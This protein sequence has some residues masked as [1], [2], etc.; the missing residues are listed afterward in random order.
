M[1]V[2]RPSAVTGR[3]RRSSASSWRACEQV[4]AAPA[5]DRRAP[6][7]RST[8]RS[9]GWRP[10]AGPPG[11][12]PRRRPRRPGGENRTRTSGRPGAGTGR[13]STSAP[14]N[15]TSTRRGRAG[16]QRRAGATSGGAARP[17]PAR[18]S[19]S[20][21]RCS[22]RPP[23]RRPGC[24][25]GARRRRP[26]RR[27]PR[28]GRPERANAGRRAGHRRGG[29]ATDGGGLAGVAAPAARLVGSPASRRAGQRPGQRPPAPSARPPPR[30]TPSCDLPAMADRPDRRRAGDGPGVAACRRQRRRR[31]VLAPRRGGGGRRRRLRPGPPRAPVRGRL[32]AS[33]S[34]DAGRDLAAPPPPPPARGLGPRAFSSVARLTNRASA[35]LRFRTPPRPRPSSPARRSPARRGGLPARAR[36]ARSPELAPQPSISA[37]GPRLT[38]S[39]R[40]CRRLGGGQPPG[41]RAL[42]SPRRV[43]ARP[44]RGLDRGEFVGP[45]LGA[46][47]PQPAAPTDAVLVDGLRHPGAELVVPIHDPGD[48][49]ERRGDSLAKPEVRPQG[50]GGSTTGSAVRPDRAASRAAST[51]GRIPRRVGQLSPAASGERRPPRTRAPS[52]RSTAAPVPH[53]RQ[54]RRRPTRGARPRPRPAAHRRR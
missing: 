8:P 14:S 27:A 49:R 51:A 24:A 31:S 42:A 1:T 17:R 33:G 32:R 36:A 52:I 39:A 50:G 13:G 38:V 22:R 30:P 41:R 2:R 19:R 23:G 20:S 28:R 15:T 10:G 12:A 18:A 47:E 21:S 7:C 9:A 34:P 35:S 25:A 43:A 29:L 48:G 5:G 44:R 46:G 45:A 53:Q 3:Q 6:G 40:L 4:G 11:R 26:N 37:G 16:R 54:G